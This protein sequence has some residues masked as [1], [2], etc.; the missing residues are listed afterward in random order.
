MVFFLQQTSV[1]F[2]PIKLQPDSNADC[3]QL[4]EEGSDWCK[5][6]LIAKVSNNALNKV[7]SE[8]V[9]N[10]VKHL[11]NAIENSKQFRVGSGYV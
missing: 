9:T 11:V 2:G 10:V 5:T 8:E 7:S 3:R 6:I 4:P 1:R